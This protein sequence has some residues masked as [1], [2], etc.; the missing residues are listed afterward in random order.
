MPLKQAF[1]LHFFRKN[2]KIQK[3]FRDFPTLHEANSNALWYAR[4]IYE[5]IMLSLNNL[6]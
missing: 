2:K 1:L 6:S 4:G 5:A 3:I